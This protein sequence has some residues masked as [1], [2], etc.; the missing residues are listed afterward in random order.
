MD[1][2]HVQPSGR[3]KKIQQAS[4]RK[5]M[6]KHFLSKAHNICIT[7]RKDHDN[8][9]I[10]KCIDKLNDKYMDSTNRVF[11]TIYSLAKRNRPFSDV[12]DEIQLQMKNG[13]DLGIGLHSAENCCENNRSHCKWIKKFLQKLL[14]IN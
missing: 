6:N 11:N 5:K 8:N 9:S 2:L 14:K 3:D 13:L 7:N 4:L 12:K 1:H 10:K